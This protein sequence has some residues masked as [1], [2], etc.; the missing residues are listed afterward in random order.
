LFV[1]PPKEWSSFYT[2]SG[3]EWQAIFWTKAAEHSAG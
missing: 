1:K 3:Q 2:V